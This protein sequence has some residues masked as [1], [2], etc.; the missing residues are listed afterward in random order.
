MY[1]LKLYVAIIR[2]CIIHVCCGAKT[3]TW[4]YYCNIRWTCTEFVCACEV[5]Y[6][7]CCMWLVTLTACLFTMCLLTPAAH[8][9]WH[10]P[11]AALS[12]CLEQLLCIM[13]PP[14][15]D[16]RKIQD[17]PSYTYLAKYQWWYHW[18]HKQALCIHFMHLCVLLVDWCVRRAHSR[19]FSFWFTILQYISVV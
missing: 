18:C 1:I 5:H 19:K 11:V 14:V 6:I 9:S 3:V 10:V 15:C 12:I 7:L 8:M 2:W 17:L 16:W 4:Y 13:P